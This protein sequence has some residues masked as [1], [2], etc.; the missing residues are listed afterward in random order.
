MRELY[1]L[2]L[3]AKQYQRFLTKNFFYEFKKIMNF[4]REK[5]LISASLHNQ[6]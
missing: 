5:M 1:F 3:W 4:K 6:Y 2:D